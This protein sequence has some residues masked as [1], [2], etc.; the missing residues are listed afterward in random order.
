MKQLLFSENKSESIVQFVK[1]CLVG[2]TN[3]AV[4][5]FLNIGILFL[6]K[7]AGWR[8]DY[9]F[10]NVTS[11]T[12]SIFWAFYWN[13]KYVFREKPDEIRNKWKA[14]G[15]TFLS[16]GFTGYVLNSILLYV[17]VD[18]AGMSK[19]IAPLAVLIVSVP[20]NFLLNKLWAFRT[21][22]GKQDSGEPRC[23]PAG[24]RPDIRDTD[25]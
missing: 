20:I 4:A 25:G 3:T 6:L 23:E 14:L 13:S 7:D 9:I 5:Y 8:W 10:A 12:I 21:A 15:K 11:F 19:Y 2:V 22:S 18:M 24:V 17:L 1:F 16:Y